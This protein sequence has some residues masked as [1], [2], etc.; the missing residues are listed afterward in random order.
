MKYPVESL[1]W[2]EKNNRPVRNQYGQPVVDPSQFEGIHFPA[3]VPAIGAPVCSCGFT[4]YR[5][6][7]G[8]WIELASHIRDM[9]EFGSLH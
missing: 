6:E 2:D 3:I 7:R 9:G 8:T 1:L 5:D 4:R